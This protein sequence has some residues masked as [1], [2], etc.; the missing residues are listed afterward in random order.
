M[1][2][3]GKPVLVWY[4]V[5]PAH[6]NLLLDH[7]R[8]V[9]AHQAWCFRAVDDEDLEK[10]LP[11]DSTETC[12]VCMAVYQVEQEIAR[13]KPAD[14]GNLARL[15]DLAYGS[16]DRQ[17]PPN[18]AAI[19][20]EDDVIWRL[21]VRAAL[22][23]TCPVLT[24]PDGV[25]AFTADRTYPIQSIHPNA[26]PAYVVL[27]NDQGQPHQLRGRIVRDYFTVAPEKT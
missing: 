26:G 21:P 23:C 12:P 11:G 6:L 7:A 1:K 15:L 4:E 16:L 14:P 13:H 25:V 20:A 19:T 10:Q 24:V 5:T 8:G 27:T 3:L 9:V 18:L 17:G 2:D 22:N